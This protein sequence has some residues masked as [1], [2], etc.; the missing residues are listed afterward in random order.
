MG[1]A[2]GTHPPTSAQRQA[3]R[4]RRAL[5][6]AAVLVC[7]A[8]DLWSVSSAGAREPAAAAPSVGTTPAAVATSTGPTAPLDP[9]GQVTGAATDSQVS[10][11]Q[12]QSSGTAESTTGATP[13]VVGSAQSAKV[14]QK[15]DGRFTVVAVPT[16][17]QRTIR[18]SGRPVRYT[19]E[20]E[21]GLGVSPDKVAS[22]IESVLLDPRGWQTQDHV[23]FV[24]VSPAQAA[25]GAQVDLRITLASP[26]TT[27]AL[28]APLETKGQVSCHNGDRVVLNLR[29]W[30]QGAA[31]YGN[32]LDGY[33]T[34][35]VNHE[36]GHGIGHAHAACGGPGQ[37]APVMMQQT[38]GL[39][40]CT[41][42][43]W[44]TPKPA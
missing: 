35:L 37:P 42:W 5:A 40:G 30:I 43:P 31:A 18:A 11:Q 3:L 6:G 20:V 16:P 19:V 2:S 4:R 29:R 41:A 25:A 1:T 17:T 34:Y 10:A 44:P 9:G 33:R 21:G 36:V 39:Q 26:D 28:C 32:D 22:K 14:V 38:Y 7:L 15:G 13:R 27:D 24:N 23:R 8:A 12:A